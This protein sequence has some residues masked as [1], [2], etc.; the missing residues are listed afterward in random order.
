MTERKG[1]KV[2]RRNSLQ[3]I[4]QDRHDQL[5]HEHA[6]HDEREG[7]QALARG[8]NPRL[9]LPAQLAGD[10]ADEDVAEDAGDVEDDQDQDDPVLGPGFDGAL[11][12]LP[13]LVECTVPRPDE[14]PFLLLALGKLN[15]VHIMYL[16]GKIFVFALGYVCVCLADISTRCILRTNMFF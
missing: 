16:V 15:Y 14:T 8:A 10:K 9:I 5:E 13:S 3:T 6:A 7:R 1:E 11:C 12:P 2:N 4:G